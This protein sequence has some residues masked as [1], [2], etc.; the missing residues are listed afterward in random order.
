[1]AM[2]TP[3]SVPGIS[4]SLQQALNQVTDSMNN[5]L[6]Q[7][8]STTTLI[9]RPGAPSTQASVFATW[10]DLMRALA[11]LPNGLGTFVQIDNSIMT[12]SIPAKPLGT[13]DM[14]GATLQGSAA[15][16]ATTLCDVEEGCVFE[17]LHHTR[18]FLALNFKAT[19]TPAIIMADGDL[20]F[21][22][23]GAMVR[24]DPA[25]AIPGIKVGANESV[26]IVLMSGGVLGSN[27]G[28]VISIDPTSMAMVLI[29]ELASISTDIAEGGGALFGVLISPTSQVFGTWPLVQPA[30]TAQ[31]LSLV[32]GGINP[33]FWLTNAPFTLVEAIN[34]IAAVV[35]NNGGNPIP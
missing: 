18:N 25:S 30:V 12:P 17:N 9:F 3:P 26:M 34:R 13:W 35:Y 14:R 19:M 33:A 10:P 1:M 4:P 29:D 16:P 24:N 23:H 11:A 20:L 8:Q 7:V 27:G 5:A 15:S 31:S 6:G 21:I 2:M 32:V 22:E 28:H